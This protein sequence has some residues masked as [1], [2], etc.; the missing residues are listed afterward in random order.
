MLLYVA[1]FN[2]K[3]SDLEAEERN[4][5]DVHV[6]LARR[7]PGL[8]LYYTGKAVESRGERPDRYRAAILMFD[9]ADAF[10]AAMQ[11]ELGP[12]LAA[13][14]E[15]HLADVVMQ[16]ADAEV[17]VPFADRR[18]GQSCFVM[19][20]EFDLAADG[21]GLEAAERHYRDK[22]VAIA[23]RLPGLRNYVIGKLRPPDPAFASPRY[24]IAILTFD[25][26]EALRAA[27]RSP[28]GQ[29]LVED[30]R[31]TIR[32]ARVLRLDGRIEV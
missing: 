15:A 27:Y 23:R 29:E 9:H 19:A 8:R 1:R 20:A 24:R 17:I 16:T 3:S 14:T 22:H 32:N 10:A 30:E 2:F 4:Y 21:G 11:T 6:A 28:V 26:P 7:M 13:D 5:F 12:A 25:S 18:P 31:A